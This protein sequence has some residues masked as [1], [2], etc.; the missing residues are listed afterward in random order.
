MDHPVLD[1]QSGKAFII[2]AMGLKRFIDK[3]KK[4]YGNTKQ[5]KRKHSK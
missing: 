1:S 5:H 2:P 4:Q 3:K